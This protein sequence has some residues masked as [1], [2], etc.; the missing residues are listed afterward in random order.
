MLTRSSGSTN[1]RKLLGTTMPTRTSKLMFRTLKRD[2]KRRLSTTLWMRVRCCDESE[3]RPWNSDGT[4]QGWALSAAAAAPFR[5]NQKCD[6]RSGTPEDWPHCLCVVD[7]AL[8]RSAR[9][10]R[11]RPNSRGASQQ[12]PT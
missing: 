2:Q 8:H 7:L 11:L 9:G 5:R 4:S 12:R 1:R 10:I 3:T 6:C